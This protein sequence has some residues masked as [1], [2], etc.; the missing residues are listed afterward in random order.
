MALLGEP[1]TVDTMLQGFLQ[2]T[3]IRHQAVLRCLPDLY[4]VEALH[5]LASDSLV[6][7]CDYKRKLDKVHRYEE[8][9]SGLGVSLE[10][11]D[12]PRPEC[13]ACGAIYN[14]TDLYSVMLR[15]NPYHIDRPESTTYGFCIYQTKILI[16]W[17][18]GAGRFDEAR[19]PRVFSRADVLITLDVM[20]KHCVEVIH[21]VVEEVEDVIR[22]STLKNVADLV[23]HA[24]PVISVAEIVA[25]YVQY[26]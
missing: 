5:M 25:Q 11:A 23:G 3:A 9:V 22:S 8:M 19:L 1:S 6:M 13:Q 10:F 16:C 15:R 21:D 2:R 7:Q 4:Y 24:I 12:N 17:T 18:L 20:C 14:R 26:I